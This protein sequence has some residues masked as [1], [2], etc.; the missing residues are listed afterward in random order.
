MAQ[1]NIDAQVADAVGRAQPD[2]WSVRP[3]AQRLCLCGPKRGRLLGSGWGV[4][5]FAVGVWGVT[6]ATTKSLLTALPPTEILVARFAVGYAALWA[7]APRRLP[8]QGWRTEAW[9]A[10][11]GVLGIA[12]YFH[13]ENLALLHA[14]A[15][16]VAVVVCTSP[17]LTALGAR[18]LG[19]AGPL[20]WRYW[21]GFALAA[22][23][24]T[25][26]V[27]GGHVEALHGAWQGVAL[28]LAGAAAWAARELARVV[29]SAP[30]LEAA[31]VRLV[32]RARSCASPDDVT[33]ALCRPLAEPRGGRADTCPT[34]I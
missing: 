12:L 1:K 6:F 3:P 18:L 5:L 28:G 2:R 32:G 13:F 24:V 23:G 10:L 14:R 30:S 27:T 11:A 16:L 25:L 26:T 20:G 19:R 9:L 22:A 15:G 7:L 4:C 33:V 34:V 17:L 31:A 21:A 29:R 8:W